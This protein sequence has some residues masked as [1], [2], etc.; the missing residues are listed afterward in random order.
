MLT[1]LVFTGRRAYDALLLEKDS[2]KFFDG[3]ESLQTRSVPALLSMENLRN[4]TL[5]R[6]TAFGLA[7]IPQ[8]E[9]WINVLRCTLYLLYD[10]STIFP[11]FSDEQAALKALI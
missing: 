11:P 9:S 2:Y 1:L 8:P 6:H 10:R 3:L 7:G 5:W 4:S